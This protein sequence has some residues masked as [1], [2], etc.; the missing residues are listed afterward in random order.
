[1]SLRETSTLYGLCTFLDCDVLFRSIRVARL[2][3]E[4]DFARYHFYDR[5]GIYRRSRELRIHSLQGCT[6]T[7][8]EEAIPLFAKYKIT[9]KL[10]YWDHCSLFLE[11]I[12]TTTADDQ[13]RYYFLSRQHAIGVSG[14]S[15]EA[16]L[17][18]L[19][20]FESKPDCP[21]NIICWLQSM[22]ISSNKLRQTIL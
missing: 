18:G 9:T 1:M 13:V 4:L 2:V 8:C 20:G 14:S 17:Q 7:L 22:K 10:I 19:Q 5:T 11:H 15:T 3:R 12:V 21:E 16:L 6:L